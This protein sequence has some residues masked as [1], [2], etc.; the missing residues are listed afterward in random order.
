MELNRVISINIE[1]FKLIWGNIRALL[2][3]EAIKHLSNR[4]EIEEKNLNN[5]E[6]EWWE[7]E[8][9]KRRSI[10]ECSLCKSTDS[11]INYSSSSSGGVCSQCSNKVDPTKLLTFIVLFPYFYRV[12]KI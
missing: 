9:L 3:C 11:N 1:R 6:N 12:R 2:H 5:L 8:R 10:C 4:S 7:L